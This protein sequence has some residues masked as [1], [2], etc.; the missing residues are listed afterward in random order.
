M[1]EL[2]IVVVADPIDAE[3]IDRLRTGPCR[4]VD[5]SKDSGALSSHLAEAWGLIVRS[6]TRVTSEL[7][8]QAPHL[9]LIARAGVGVDNVDLRAA[10]ARGI[11]VVNAP[12]AATVSVAEL[13]VAFCLLLARGFYPQVVA[14]KAGRWERGTHGHE[15]AGKT[16]GLVGYGHI[17]REVAR[18]LVPFGASVI[19]YDP[20]VTRTGDA[21][22]LVSLDDL[23]R[24]SDLISLHAALT[25]ENHHLIGAAA[26]ERMKP[27]VLLVNVAR[28]PLIDEG[29]LL[30]ALRWGRIGGVALDV[31][32]IEP[33]KNREL[34][35]HPNVI[36]TPHIGASTLEAQR[37][38]GADIVEE[39]LHALQ[40]EPLTA[41]VAPA[42]GAR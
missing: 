23:F 15:V 4:V 3:A 42:G 22:E 33:P 1:V 26:L 40:G 7:I 5:A 31:F 30:E 36:A 12:V 6:R 21:T 29:A 37:R 41:L 38:A 27:G 8:A 34:L 16:V 9:K 13:T 24:R 39:V 11:Q 25:P 17:G 18:R 28:G 10:S 19:A 2:P 32:E 14:A 35:E 20:F